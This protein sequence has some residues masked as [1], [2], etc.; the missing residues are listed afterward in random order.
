MNY[1]K[2]I[3]LLKEEQDDDDLLLH[4][5]LVIKRKR[6]PIKELYKSRTQEG[7]F[8]I[9][10]ERHVKGDEEL[11]RKFSRLNYDQF[12]FVLSLVHEDLKSHTTRKT[13]TE[14]EK[15]FITL[16]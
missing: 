7:S 14:E 12:N 8:N 9:L 5:L 16:R 10:I 13:I 15:L 1:K 4:Y 11:F 2:L 6:K 3:D